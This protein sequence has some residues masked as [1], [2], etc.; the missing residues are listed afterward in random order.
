MTSGD[1]VTLAIREAEEFAG[2]LP[3]T[4]ELRRQVQ[5]KLIEARRDER[6]FSH[7][8]WDDL[9]RCLLDNVLLRLRAEGRR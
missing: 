7:S 1:H 6:I 5:I 3:L 2:S 4:P 9:H 8:D